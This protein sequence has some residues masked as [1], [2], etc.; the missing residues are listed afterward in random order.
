[1]SPLLFQLVNVSPIGDDCL[2]G[3]C[4][5]EKSPDQRFQGTCNYE[6]SCY[7]QHI[8]RLD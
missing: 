7:G 2:I 6:L 3:Y 1:M 8:M 4:S 5:V